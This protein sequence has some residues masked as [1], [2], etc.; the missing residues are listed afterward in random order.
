MLVLWDVNVD[1]TNPNLKKAREANEL[2]SDLEGANTAVEKK[3]DP[4]IT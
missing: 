2:L 4:P 1:H 3:I